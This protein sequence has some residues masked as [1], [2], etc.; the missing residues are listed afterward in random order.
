M[1]YTLTLNPAIDYVINPV[2][3]KIGEIN[4]SKNENIYFGGKGINVSLVLE[5]LDI[6]SVVMGFIAGFT[7]KALQEGIESKFIKSDFVNLS[8]GI[9]RINVKIRHGNETDIN[10]NGPKVTEKD[11]AKLYEKLDSLQNG[12]ILVMSGSVPSNLPHNIYE[13]IMSRLSSKGV[14]FIVD[15]EKDLLLNSLKYNPFLIKPNNI[16]LG[17]IFSVKIGTNEAALK[18]AKELQEMGAQNVL[19]SLGDKGA[20]L[21]DK[22]GKNYFASAFE[23]DASN[24]VGAGD[25]MLAG[26][27]AGYILK[28]DFEYALMLGTASGGATAFSEGLAKKHQIEDLLK[29]RIR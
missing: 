18:Y 23:G 25:S 19:I 3:L 27:I 21:I 8:E 28:E 16:E 5:E 6:K 26:F 20:V 7:G 29:K 15:A 13:T 17:E 4:R 12:D 9:T 1:I 14:Q 2:D 11:I 22:N 24:T 10:M